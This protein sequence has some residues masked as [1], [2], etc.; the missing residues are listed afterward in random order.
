MLISQSLFCQLNVDPWHSSVFHRE[1]ISILYLI[2]IFYS[3]S[4]PITLVPQSLNITMTP[5]TGSVYSLP[6]S[7]DTISRLCLNENASPLHSNGFTA[8][9]LHPLRIVRKTANEWEAP[10]GESTPFRVDIGFN[11]LHDI[12][13]VSRHFQNGTKRI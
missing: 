11:R 13:L 1:V 5:F 7:F 3:S 4:L 10:R 6:F 9:F 12:G 2:I 8:C